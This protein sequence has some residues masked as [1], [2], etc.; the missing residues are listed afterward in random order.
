MAAHQTPLSLGFSRQE[1]WSGLPFPSPGDLPDSGIKPVSPAWEADSLPLRLSIDCFEKLDIQDPFPSSIQ[2]KQLILVNIWDFIFVV[3]H[4]L[5]L[6][7]SF[8]IRDI[9]SFLK[10]MSVFFYYV[11]HSLSL[12]LQITLKG[13]RLFCGYFLMLPHADLYSHSSPVVTFT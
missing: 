11:F 4:E 7:P 1:Y 9:S 3:L 12:Y 5:C 8:W 13:I 6:R 2:P 10:L